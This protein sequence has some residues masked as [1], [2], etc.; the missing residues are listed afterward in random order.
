[1]LTTIRSHAAAKPHSVRRRSGRIFRRTFPASF[2]TPGAGGEGSVKLLF[3]LRAR[4]GDLREE[5]FVFRQEVLD[6]AGTL[7]GAVRVLQIEVVVAGIDLVDGYAPG[8]FVFHAGL[9][10]VGLIAP[11]GLFGCE[12]LDAD[13]L[14][15]VVALHTR[16]IRV[17]VI[18]DLFR[19][20]AFREEEQVGP[21]TGVGIEDAIGKADDGVQVALG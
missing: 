19:W 1:M 16:R 18:P 20:R 6:V 14:A 3:Q 15:L 17:L 10:A 12:L 9:E 21:D 7:V 4:F 5:L 13:G 8:V 11:P 2:D